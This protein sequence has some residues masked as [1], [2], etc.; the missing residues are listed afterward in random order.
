MPGVNMELASG[1]NTI[2]LLLLSL[3]LMLRVKTHRP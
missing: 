3:F 2:I 1:L